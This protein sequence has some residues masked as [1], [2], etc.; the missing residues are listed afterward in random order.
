MGATLQAEVKQAHNYAFLRKMHAL[1]KLAYDHFVEYG[2]GE[3]TY[4][5]QRVTPDYDRFRKDLTILAGHY[6][7][8]FRIDGSVRLEAKSIS[9]D[10]ADNEAREK[11]FD[12]VL[13][14]ALDRVY[15]GSMSEGQLRYLIEQ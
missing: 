2:V 1:F 5:G 6:T 8:V 11:I 9:Y 4:K 14:V 15:R 7:P 12:D 10:K 3:Q 13:N